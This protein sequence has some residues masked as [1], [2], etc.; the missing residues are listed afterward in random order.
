MSK[1]VKSITLIPESGMADAIKAIKAKGAALDQAIHVAAVSAIAIADRKDGTGNIHYVNALYKAMPKG[2]RHVA[3]T[4]WLLAFGGVVANTGG[5]KEDAPFILDKTEGAH[6][7]LDGAKAN[8]W[9]NFAPSKAPDEVLDVAA[10]TL[11]LIAKA[12]KRQDKDPDAVKG[13]EMLAELEQLAAKYAEV[14]GEDIQ[15]V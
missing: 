1:Q 9:Y 6:V 7:D 13:V 10:L 8:P 4:N 5:N 3:L 11:K 15:S 2:A 12:K 14:A